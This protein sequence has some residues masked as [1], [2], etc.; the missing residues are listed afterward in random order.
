MKDVIKKIIIR[1]DCDNKPV[2]IIQFKI[3]GYKS[4]C[5]V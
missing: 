2:I 4:H 5:V 1:H 3:F